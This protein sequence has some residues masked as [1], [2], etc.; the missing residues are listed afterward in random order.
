MGNEF[1]FLLNFPDVFCLYI[2]V[3]TSSHWI[4]KKS[5][6]PQ[7]IL[8]INVK[9]LWERTIEIPD[10]FSYQRAFYLCLTRYAKRRQ[11]KL[12]AIFELKLFYLKNARP[13][14]TTNKQSTEITAWNVSKHI[15]LNSEVRSAEP[16]CGRLQKNQLW[17]HKFSFPTIFQ[18]SFRALYDS[19]DLKRHFSTCNISAMQ[20]PITLKLRDMFIWLALK[21]IFFN[22]QIDLVTII[23]N[24]LLW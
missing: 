13:R 7:I 22:M 15:Y 2:V 23:F 5:V 20:C 14:T 21:I 18:Q 19:E 24:Y 12:L 3:R 16:V 17:H 10:L 11:T 1:I 8:L 6:Q 9:C 4:F